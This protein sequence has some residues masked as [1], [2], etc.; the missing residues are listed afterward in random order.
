MTTKQRNQMSAA[1]ER[2]EAKRVAHEAMMAQ[3]EAHRA[4]QQAA[5]AAMK[6]YNA[7]WS[8]WLRDGCKG[9]KPVHP[10]NVRGIVRRDDDSDLVSAAAE[11]GIDIAA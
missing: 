8:A 5:R 4:N 7:Y 9:P 6:A 10:D 2:R 3:H 1:A 11:L